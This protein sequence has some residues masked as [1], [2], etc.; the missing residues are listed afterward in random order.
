LETLGRA[1]AERCMAPSGHP[2]PMRLAAFC[3][4]GL[5]C[6]SAFANAEGEEEPPAQAEAAAAEVGAAV[7]EAQSP[8]DSARE[9]QAKLTQLQDLMEKS[10]LKD[11]D[12]LKEKLAGLKKQ[13]SGL[14]LDDLG[15]EGSS[16]EL[17]QFINVCVLLSLRR[18]GISRSA[19]ASAF[20]QIAV[21]S[22]SLE[23]VIGLELAKMIGVCILEASDEEYKM[24]QAGTILTLPAHMVER[25]KSKDI[26]ETILK[27]MDKQLW[28]TVK[29]VAAQGIDKMKAQVKESG[30]PM[31]WGIL[32]GVPVV[33]AVAFLAFKF[34]ALQKEKEQKKDKKGSKKSK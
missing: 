28:S 23:D 27:G 12:E 19:T 9:L 11:S 30:L 18:A 26:K 10:G 5:V 33:G 22:S 21:A 4:L 25:A 16:K 32:A 34:L 17:T 15:G 31:S 7:E 29:E 13:L 3:A 6:W 8:L 20:K 2:R 14:G 24:M 1:P